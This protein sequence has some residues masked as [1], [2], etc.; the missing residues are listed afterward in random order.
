MTIE[1]LYEWAKENGVEKY[2]LKLEYHPDYDINADNDLF[3]DDEQKVVTI[4][5]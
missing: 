1:E 5:I 2:A 4:I 3:S